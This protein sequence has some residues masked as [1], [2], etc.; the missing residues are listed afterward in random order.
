[1]SCVGSGTSEAKYKEA[2]GEVLKVGD[3]SDSQ[4]QRRDMRIFMSI[5]P[6]L[7]KACASDRLIHIVIFDDFQLNDSFSPWRRN[8]S[9]CGI[10]L[11]KQQASLDWER[12]P[13]IPICWRDMI[14]RE[15]GT[16]ARQFVVILA[17]RGCTLTTILT[18]RQSCLGGGLDTPCSRA[19]GL[20]LSKIAPFTKWPP[21]S[22]SRAAMVAEN[23]K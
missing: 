19:A 12:W 17:I 4:H 20:Q 5:P 1:M 9:S 18:A 13:Q 23:S 14:G 21:P 10:S 11:L 15:R 22:R 7:E 6:I 16:R 8:T 3:D 2:T